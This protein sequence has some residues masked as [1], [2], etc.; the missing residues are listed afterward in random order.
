MK[1]KTIFMLGGGK[2]WHGTDTF[3]KILT[4][5]PLSYSIYRKWDQP[6]TINFIKLLLSLKITDRVTF[7]DWIGPEEQKT[8]F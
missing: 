5:L 4:H 8:V 2:P 7:L 3:L 6:G 1:K